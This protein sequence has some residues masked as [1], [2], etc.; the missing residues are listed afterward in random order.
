VPEPL[1]AAL[2]GLRAALLDQHGLVRAVASGRRRGAEPPPDA[3]V[4]LRPVQLKTGRH[5]QVVRR[6]GPRVQ[7]ANAAYDRDAP[8][9][10][11]ALLAAPYGN[12][13]VDTVTGTVQL[14]V[15]KSAEAQ[16]HRTRAD[17]APASGV[18][19]RPSAHLLDPGD[20]VFDVVGGGADKRRQV[21]AFL[22]SL[23]PALAAVADRVPLRVVDLGCGNAYL[24]FG[25]YR[26]LT[27]NRG[28][29][30]EL[31][32]VDLRAQAR[33]RNSGLAEALGWAEHARFVEGSVLEAPLE[34]ADVVLALHACDTATDEA[35]ARAVRWRA[36]VVLA[37]PC[38]HHDLQAQLR[39]SAHPGPPAPYGLLTR[40]PVLLERAADALTDALRAALLRLLGYRVEVL[41]F[42]DSAHTPRN[43]LLRAVRTGAAPPP[44][45]VAEY[46]DL[47]TAW[48]VRPCLAELLGP[49]LAPVLGR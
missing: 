20:P 49:E 11:D 40:H 6:D 30:V 7:T 44:E 46:L 10:I 43:I 14:R 1:A 4:E 9:V 24:T 47:V 17:R 22:R 23:Q 26:H 18:H 42:V 45:L 33:E 32:G 41:E 29:S 13:H 19:D 15:T 37:A 25:A 38:C 36:P 35:L 2:S 27:A 48:Q 16:V 5:L 3:R 12:W 31:T 39:A 21:D 8:A 34:G 28:L